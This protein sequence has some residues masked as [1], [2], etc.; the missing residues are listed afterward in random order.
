MIR[1]NE[2]CFDFSP[3]LKRERKRAKKRK[4]AGKDEV[5]PQDDLL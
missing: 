3:E 5:F 1:V 4:K 2:Q